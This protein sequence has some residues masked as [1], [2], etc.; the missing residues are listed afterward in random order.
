M[1]PSL[2]YILLLFTEEPP[3]IW[4]L[5][6]L[7][8]CLS[9]LCF[10]LFSNGLVQ[11]LGLQAQLPL[12]QPLSKNLNTLCSESS[13]PIISRIWVVEFLSCQGRWPPSH[14]LLTVDPLA[15]ILAPPASFQPAWYPQVCSFDHYGTFLDQTYMSIKNTKGRRQQ[16]ENLK[17]YG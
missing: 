5:A 13:T 7:Q 1:S 9:V 11:A 10:L 16:K 15:L 12:P 4:C 3:D 14:L 2:L 8:Q 17:E 6:W